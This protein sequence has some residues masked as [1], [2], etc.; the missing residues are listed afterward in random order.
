MY[1][2][3]G[4]LYAMQHVAIA[5]RLPFLPLSSVH[6]RCFPWFLSFKGF[7]AFSRGSAFSGFPGFT[8]RCPAKCGNVW[9]DWGQAGAGC[10]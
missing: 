2:A 4:C 1:A 10:G 8:R 9:V 3:I 7:P 6:N 5:V